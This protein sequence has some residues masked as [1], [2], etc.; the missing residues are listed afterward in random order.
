MVL[1]YRGE[2]QEVILS[3]QDGLSIPESSGKQKQPDYHHL[4]LLSPQLQG[5]MIL[6]LKLLV[7]LSSM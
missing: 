4:F 7:Q 3:L 6:C 2:N 1:E 5:S